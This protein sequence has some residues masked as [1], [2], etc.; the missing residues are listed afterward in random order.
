MYTDPR[1]DKYRYRDI[2]NREAEH[3]TVSI[4]SVICICYSKSI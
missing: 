4:Y 2:C 1:K 3:F